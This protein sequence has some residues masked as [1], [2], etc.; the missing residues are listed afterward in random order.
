MCSL[1]EDN[2]R[3]APATKPDDL[4]LSPQDPQGTGENQGL[5]AA[6]NLHMSV[7]ACVYACVRAQTLHTHAH[8]HTKYK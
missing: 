2:H 6:P 4:S 5:Q 8:A 1:W 7:A 3:L